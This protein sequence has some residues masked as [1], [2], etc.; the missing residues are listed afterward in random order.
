[1]PKEVAFPSDVEGSVTVEGQARVVTPVQTT[2]DR[3]FASLDDLMHIFPD[4]E[5][6]VP[7]DRDSS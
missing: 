3:F 1:M 2:W 5:Q 4:R 7:Q 6:P